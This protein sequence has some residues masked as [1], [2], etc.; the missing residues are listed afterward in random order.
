[1][2]K[3]KISKEE[4]LQLSKKLRNWVQGHFN[5]EELEAIDRFIQLASSGASF[6]QI[7]Q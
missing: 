2:D 7:G 5:P 4:W 6:D 3:R 1:M